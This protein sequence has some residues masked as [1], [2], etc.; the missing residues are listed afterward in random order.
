MK[1]AYTQVLMPWIYG[2]IKMCYVRTKQKK[3]SILFPLNRCLVV[4]YSILHLMKQNRAQRI[5]FMSTTLFDLTERWSQ[6]LAKRSQKQAE[7][8]RKTCKYFS[9]E[10]LIY[11]I[12]AYWSSY[13]LSTLQF[14]TFFRSSRNI[15][16]IRYFHWIHGC[17]HHLNRFAGRKYDKLV[18]YTKSAVD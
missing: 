11:W 1:K 8:R 15:D 14:T 10:K 7:S 17:I 5:H 6:N 2:I 12:D 18:K 16:P 13:K 4:G 9:F 3:L